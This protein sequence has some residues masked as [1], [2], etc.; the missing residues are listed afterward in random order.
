[1]KHDDTAASQQS[2]RDNT[3]IGGRMSRYLVSFQSAGCLPDSDPI[4]FDS[5][6]T[7]AEHIA[8]EWLEAFT[9]LSD[10]PYSGE[11]FVSRDAIETM[12]R[13]KCPE[14]ASAEAH[15]LAGLVAMARRIDFPADGSL[16]SWIID[17]VD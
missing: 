2:G 17:R 1:M 15:M 3:K 9:S 8:E 14:D 13:V 16:Y 12:Q 5:I 11:P 6:W 7:A 4:E 10:S